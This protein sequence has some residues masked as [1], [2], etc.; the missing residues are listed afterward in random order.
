MFIKARRGENI[1]MSKCKNLKS[2]HGIT[3]A[4]EGEHC[5]VYEEKS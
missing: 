5:K 4:A 2:D 1:K 3:K